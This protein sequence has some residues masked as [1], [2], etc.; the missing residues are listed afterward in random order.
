M[1]FPFKSGDASGCRC[2][3]WFGKTCYATCSADIADHYL[4]EPVTKTEVDK[5]AYVGCNVQGSPKRRLLLGCGMSSIG[6]SSERGKIAP[7]LRRTTRRTVPVT[8][9]SATSGATPSAATSE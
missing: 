2:Y 1:G 9:S 5:V 8:T 6:Q 4:P 7:C 3:A